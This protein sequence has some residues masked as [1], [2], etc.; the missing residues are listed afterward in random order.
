MLGE[1]GSGKDFLATFI[2]RHSKRATGPF[3]AINC[4]A[5]STEL[6]ESELFGHEAGAFTDAKG[7]KLGLL[8]LAEGGTLLLNEIGELPLDLQVKLLTFL[9]S[10]SFTRV[11]GQK[12]IKTDARIMAA[13]NRNLEKEVL[14][15]RFRADLYYRL[16]VFSITTPPLRDRKED[17]PIIVEELLL[18]N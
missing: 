5:L 2:H 1:S 15:G 8:E 4:G 14:G 3:F 17:V 6:A 13:T 12:A 9:D 11:G 18:R 16:N 7:R 10:K